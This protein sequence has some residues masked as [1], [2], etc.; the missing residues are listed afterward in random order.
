[1]YQRHL[2]NKSELLYLYNTAGKTLNW[3]S[4]DRLEVFEKNRDK[5]DPYYLDLEITYEFNSAGYRTAE[6]DQYTT[7]Q[8]FIAM[9]CSYTAG[10]GLLKSDRWS[11][12]LAELL[13]LPDMNLGISGAGI[14]VAMFN[15]VNYINSDLPRPKFVAIQVPEFTRRVDWF[16]E[17]LPE[18]PSDVY[19]EVT[20][21]PAYNIE[22]FYNKISQADT[23]HSVQITPIINAAYYCEIIKYYWQSIGVPVYFWCFSG[24]ADMI[25]SYTDLELLSIP[26]DYPGLTWPAD[27][28]R[29]C[30][31]DGRHAHHIAATLIYEHIKEKHHER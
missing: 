27:K 30:A 8:F 17:K 4:S 24:D 7:D 23:D 20:D 29:D 10:E 1:M 21:D 9:G 12:Q 13:E 3:F 26:E 2:N 15:T 5:V 18:A 6:F 25:K 28:A 31:H 22:H 16:R 11:D 14:D 19:C